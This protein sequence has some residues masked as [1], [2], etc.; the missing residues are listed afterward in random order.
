MKIKSSS[1]ERGIKLYQIGINKFLG[2]SLIRRIESNVFNTNEDLQRILISHGTDGRGEWVDLAGLI[3]PKSEVE[4]LLGQIES[5]KLTSSA[6]LNKSFS[7]L[8]KSYFEWEWTWACEKIEEEIGITVNKLTATDVID[9]LERW[10]KSV[11]E[12]DNLIYEDAEKEFAST[13]MTGFGIDGG[14]D[15]RKLDFKNVRGDFQTN[16]FVMSIT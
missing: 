1:F 4:K 7:G 13:S 11:L 9:L 2:N 10:K 8:H 3:T 5:G 16:S 6:D 15:I 12:L 14:D